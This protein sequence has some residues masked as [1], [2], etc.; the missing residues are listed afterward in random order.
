MSHWIYIEREDKTDLMV[1]PYPT[2]EAAAHAMNN[3]L[4][5]DA[6]CEENCVDCYTTEE[7]PVLETVVHVN[8]DDPDH[9]GVGERDDDAILTLLNIDYTEAK[10]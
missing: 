8:M 2:I 5:V 9:T 4:L 7:E 6:L 3:A 10:P 1:G